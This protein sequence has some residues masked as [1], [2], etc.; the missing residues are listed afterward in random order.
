MM[1]VLVRAGHKGTR[2][3][4]IRAGSLDDDYDDEADE[5]ASEI[6]RLKNRSLPH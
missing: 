4:R 1:S 5:G 6:T 3:E 2:F